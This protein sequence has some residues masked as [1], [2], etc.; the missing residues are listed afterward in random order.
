MT[1]GLTRRDRLALIILSVAVVIAVYFG[2]RV[3]WFLTD[4][5]FIAF[6]YVSNSQLGYGYVWNPPPFRPVEGYTSFLWVVLLDVVWRVTGKEP[7]DVANVLSLIFAY[8][9]LAI[10]ALIVLKMDLRAELARYRVLLLALV[11]V[12]VISNR[13]FL[14]WT[15]SGLETALFNFC[16]TSWIY[17]CLFLKTGTWRSVFAMSLAAVALTLTRPDGLLFAGATVFLIAFAIYG[18]V[19][20]SRRAAL[21]LT[22]AAAPLL[23]IPVHLIWRRA[24]YKSWLPNT[25][26][27]KTI[28]GRFWYQSGTRYFLSFVLE[29]A[30]WIWLIVFLAVAVIE[31]RRFL[32]S[33]KINS[34]ELG[35]LV[36]GAAVFGQIFYYTAVI[37][38]DHFEY[39]VYSQLILLTPISFL[40]LLNRLQLTPRS[41]VLAISL[42]IACSWPIPW[43][44]WSATYNILGRKRSVVLRASVAYAIQK[45]FPGTPGILLAYPR[46]FDRLQ[47]WLI[48]HYVC[49]RHQEHKNFYLYL[50]ETLPSRE[51]GMTL[52][53]EN[54][55]VHV[56]SSVGVVSWVLPR[57]NVIDILGLNDYVAARNQD[58]TSFI[59]MAHERRPPDGYIECFEPNVDFIQDHFDVH[60]RP[61]P[62]TAE[63]IK[64]CEE[65]FAALVEGPAG[66]RA[67]VPVK[68]PI[69]ERHF[70]VSQEYRDVLNREPD[71][72][73]LDYWSEHLKPCPT[74]TTCFNQSRA[75][76]HMVLFSAEEFQESAIFA[77]RLHAAAFG[78]APRF[79]DFRQDRKQFEDLHVKDWR[80]P[81]EFVPAQRSFTVNWVLRDEFRNAYP[82]SMK[83][84]EFVNQLFDTAQLKPFEEERKRNIEALR[85]GK[86]RSEVLREVVELEE[87]KRRENDRAQLMLQFLVHLRRDVD[88]NDEHYKAELEKLSRG[89]KVDQ[90]KFI[91]L[92]LTSEEYQRRFGEIVTHNNSECH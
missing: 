50:K 8:L 28:A 32:K 89:E 45:R 75:L 26:Y 25:Y 3:F 65:Q 18:K 78:H 33:K 62:L 30:L 27:A 11:L 59:V 37:G 49:M 77:Y 54:Y 15:S 46:A 9:T 29:Y 10:G 44:H 60:E 79:V 19:E 5:A 47:D 24:V 56:A 92:F 43:I 83:A 36:V 4:D 74:G 7:P 2:W 39:R 42:F 16:L 40:W 88:Y 64:T 84:E 70:F 20:T 86:S 55:P 38:G 1:E 71:P 17:C 52:P 58:V 13:T 68:N 35:A 22:L 69:D 6:R 41:T 51:A 66:R 23:T 91:C 73:G 12:W 81:E 31:A 34:P 85:A 61:I 67:P 76:I 63:R 82:Q 14:A 90:R 21:K 48:G 53:V 72:N 80:D 87:F 57:V